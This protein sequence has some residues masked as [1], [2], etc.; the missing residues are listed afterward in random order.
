MV[1]FAL[2]KARS[3]RYRHAARHLLEC[4]SLA[5]QIEDWGCFESHANWLDKIRQKHKR[6]LGFWRHVE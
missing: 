6:K 5:A 2:N 4:E 3:K 1:E